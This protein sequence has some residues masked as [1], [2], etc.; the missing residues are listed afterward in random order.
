M[1]TG[2]RGF[3]A[4]TG[5]DRYV[6]T[7]A[8]CA[9]L[10]QLPRPHLANSSSELAFKGM[11]GRLS[12]KRQTIWAELCVFGLTDD[13]AVFAAPDAQDLPDQ[14]AQYERFTNAATMIGIGRPPSLSAPINGK[15]RR[16]R[17]H[18]CSRSTANWRSCVVHSTGR[19][20]SITSG[21]RGIIEGGM[22]GSPIIDTYGAA[23]GLVSTGDYSLNRHPSLMDC[24]PPWLLRELRPDNAKPAMP[25]AAEANSA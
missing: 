11:I 15:P 23:I 14:N 12:S 5:I 9:P 7:A 13:V 19:F 2:G 8:H 25:L 3:I 10:E 20:L 17:P 18:G 16:G 6:V 24:L 4:G 1:N 22:S 21:A